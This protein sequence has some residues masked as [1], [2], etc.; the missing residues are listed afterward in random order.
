MNTLKKAEAKGREEG[1]A[2]GK[3]EGLAEGEKKRNLE[4]ARNLLSKG[5]DIK[6]ISETT[7]LTEE[8]IKKL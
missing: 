6:L 4:I 7:G 8:E 2:E 3:A 1:R 5:V